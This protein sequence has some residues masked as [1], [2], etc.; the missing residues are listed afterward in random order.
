LAPQQPSV[1]DLPKVLAVGIAS[2]AAAAITARF[3]V[4][5]TLLGLVLSSVFVTAGVD[6]LKVYLARVPGAVTSIPGGFRQKSALGRLLQR[7]RQPFS[8]FASLPHS[9]RRS[10]LIGSIAAAG[11]SCLVGL[12]IVTGVEASV[13]KSLSCSVWNECPTESST[14]TTGDGSTSQTKSTLPSILGGGQGAISS[15]TLQATP[16]N[17]QQEPGSSSGTQQA[18]SQTPPVVSGAGTP[19][20]ET[21]TPSSPSPQAG[22]RQGPSGVSQDQQQPAPSS[23]PADQ[24][25]SSS[26]QQSNSSDQQSSSSRTLQ[27]GYRSSE[28]PRRGF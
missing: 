7:M 16:S 24:Q 3:G 6:F 28:L 21:A 5:G 18:P 23:A 27:E 10:L 9:R 12:I 8:K 22:Q 26:D 14:T 13:G 19:G 20:V 25:S 1:F 15:T 2:P 4:A 11:L 17:P